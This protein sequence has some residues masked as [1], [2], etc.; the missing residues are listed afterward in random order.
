VKKGNEKETITVLLVFSADGRTL[1][2]MVVFPF[3]RPNKAIVDS[4]PSGWFL[5]RSESGWMRSDTFYERI[6]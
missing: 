4:I 6:K 5:G 2:P 3:V 1:T